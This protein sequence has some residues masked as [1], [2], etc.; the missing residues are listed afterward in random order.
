MSRYGAMHVIGMAYIGTSNNAAIK[1]LLHF[2]S[3]DFSDDVRRGAVINL[4]F[5][6]LKHPEQ[7]VLTSSL[8]N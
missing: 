7:V 2:A 4:S 3:A 1:K 8:T 5:V 6:L